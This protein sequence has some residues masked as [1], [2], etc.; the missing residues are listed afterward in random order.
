MEYILLAVVILL[1]IILF[2][3]REHSSN[4][5]K[6]ELESNKKPTDSEVSVDMIAFRSDDPKKAKYTRHW[7]HDDW[8]LNSSEKYYQ[9]LHY[10]TSGVAAA[11]PMGQTMFD[12]PAGSPP[13][14]GMSEVDRLG[15]EVLEDQI[16]SGGP[17]RPLGTFKFRDNFVGSAEDPVS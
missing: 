4:L 6:P 7:D 9:K 11:D 5:P 8:G 2:A 16:R 14:P 10:Y 17:I 13:L 1:V 15:H 12:D 3:R